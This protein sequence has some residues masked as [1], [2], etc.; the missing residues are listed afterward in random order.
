[1]KNNRYGFC[2]VFNDDG[3]VLVLRRSHAARSRPGEWDLAGGVIEDHETTEE[4]VKREVFEEAGLAVEC[5]EFVTSR[6]GEW[7]GEH[8]EFSY[9]RSNTPTPN[10]VLSPEHSSYEW[11]LPLVASSMVGYKPH[12]AAYSYIVD[13]NPLTVQ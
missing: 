13:S 7:D 1:M 8:H 9:Y 4:G 5:L 12:R 2:F 3:Q 11:H 6:S 10:I